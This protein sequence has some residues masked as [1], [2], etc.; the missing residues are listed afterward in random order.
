[1]AFTFG[2]GRSREGKVHLAP[3]FSLAAACGNGGGRVVDAPGLSV[4]TCKTCLRMAARVLR[5]ARVELQR[6]KKGRQP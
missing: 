3:G 4:V 2:R 6:A 5:E 1:M